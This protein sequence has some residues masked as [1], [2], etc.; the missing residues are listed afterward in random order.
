MAASRVTGLEGEPSGGGRKLMTAWYCTVRRAG[1]D[2]SPPESP[3]DSIRPGGEN[4][5]LAAP[6]PSRTS[7]RLRPFFMLVSLL[8]RPLPAFEPSDRDSERESPPAPDADPPDTRRPES[9]SEPRPLA[10]TSK[11]PLPQHEIQCQTGFGPD[12]IQWMTRRRDLAKRS[13]AQTALPRPCP[14]G[15]TGRHAWFRSTFRKVVQVQ[16]LSRVPK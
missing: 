13:F 4:R 11:V 1:F 16:V 10:M 8:L 15:G 7:R 9:R 3:R 5:A 12:V 2:A 6:P 14:G